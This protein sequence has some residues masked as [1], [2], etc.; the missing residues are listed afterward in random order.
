VNGAGERPG[1]GDSAVSDDASQDVPAS[2]TDS[3][4]TGSSSEP[5]VGATSG[6]ATTATSG[7][8]GSTPDPAAP[9]LPG[10]QQGAPGVTSCGASGDSC[11]TSDE[12]EGG[13]YYRT[14]DPI[15]QDGG[16]IWAEIAPD[17]GAAGLADPATISAF[18]LDKYDV[19]VG[20]FRQ[21]VSAWNRGAGWTPPAGS[22]KHT[23]LNG[24]RG[25]ADSASPGNYESG[26][27][28]ADNGKIAPTDVNLACDPNY[29]TWTASAADNETKP[30]ICENWYEAY[31]FCIWDGGFLP[32]ETESEYAAAG[33][34]QQR[35]YPWGSADPLNDKRYAIYDCDYPGAFGG[36]TNAKN[37]APVGTSTLGAGRW[38]Q[39]D[40]VGN[41]E[42]WNLDWYA[43]YANPCTDCAYLA[44]TPDRVT[45]GSDLLSTTLAL[46][47]SQR[48]SPYA[49]TDRVFAGI[50][51]ART[52]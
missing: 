41:V 17:G 42:Q 46:V 48:P 6:S 39:L 31:A 3:S 20:R 25:L 34:S 10:C 30:I 52:P 32:S 9:A 26:W 13:T 28:P 27:M 33:G 43:D 18:R 11:C 23:H 7:T 44:S 8:S 5:T 29:A 51:C 37:I 14:Y 45:R 35:E 38:G 21:F 36:C 16:A 12:V 15:L 49:P 40:L 1:A 2:A 22:G 24:G 47:A 4:V 19:T 50:R